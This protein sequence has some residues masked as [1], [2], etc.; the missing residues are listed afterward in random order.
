MLYTIY[1][2]KYYILNT[3]Y[4]KNTKYFKVCPTESP[5]LTKYFKSRVSIIT[6][7]Y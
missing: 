5:T 3:N 4:I 7:L 6:L 1:Y 2:T